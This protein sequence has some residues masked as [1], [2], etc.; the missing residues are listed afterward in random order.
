VL[1]L[2]RRGIEVVSVR[3]PWLDAGGA[4]RPLLIA[5]FGWIAEQ[6]RVRLSERTRAGMDRARRSG[7]HVGRPSSS[8]DVQ[9]ALAMKHDGLKVPD[10]AARL[11]VSPATLKRAFGRL[12]RGSSPGTI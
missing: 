9:R 3:E 4:V 2:D 5:I 6:E 8:I 7:V 11:R 10:I 12:K 1:D